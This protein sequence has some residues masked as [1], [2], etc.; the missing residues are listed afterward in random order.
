MPTEHAVGR[1]RI[2]LIRDDITTLDIDAFVFYARRDLVLGAELRVVGDQDDLTLA[3]PPVRTDANLGDE[4][5][6]RR[7]DHGALRALDDQPDVFGRYES[8]L[9][10]VRSQVAMQWRKGPA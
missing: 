8:L 2:R 1:S 3:N 10:F 4:P 5:R 7:R 9:G 6:G